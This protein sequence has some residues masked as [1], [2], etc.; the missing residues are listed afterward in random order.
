MSK[1]VLFLSLLGVIILLTFGIADPNSPVV[2][3]ASTSHNFAYLRLG[4]I[5]ALLALLVTNPPRNVYLRTFVG[6]AALAMVS[7]SLSATYNNHMKFLDTLS[8]LE[9]S[10]SAGLV[11]LE[12]DYEEVVEQLQ[13]STAKKKPARR[14]TKAKLATA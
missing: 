1:L 13:K 14:K 5:V 3:L 11:V 10:I 7:W 9:V 2:W 12:R 6:A 8:I 4:M